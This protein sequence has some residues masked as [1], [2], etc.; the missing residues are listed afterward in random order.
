MDIPLLGLRLIND[1]SP[2]TVYDLPYEEEVDIVKELAKWV[3]FGGLI[4]LPASDAACL[5]FIQGLRTSF[6]P[7]QHIYSIITG[8]PK[9]KKSGSPFSQAVQ[10]M[11]LRIGD[12]RAAALEVYY[13]GDFIRFITDTEENIYNVVKSKAVVE[14]LAA[15]RGA[16]ES[17]S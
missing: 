16:G 8:R 15:L 10:G 14:R 2:R 6:T 17:A 1:Y 4:L 13:K 7:G 9:P 3:N 12:V 11:G 5:S